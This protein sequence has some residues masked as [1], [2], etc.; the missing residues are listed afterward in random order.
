MTALASHPN[1]WLPALCSW[2]LFPRLAVESC[3]ISLQFLVTPAEPTSK[4]ELQARDTDVSF[5]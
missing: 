3:H 1:L 2:L 5:T 4:N